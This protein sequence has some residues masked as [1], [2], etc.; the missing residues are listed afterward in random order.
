MKLSL[1]KPISYFKTHAEELLEGLEES[2]EPIAITQNGEVRAVVQNAASFERTQ[3]A[4]ALLRLL[5]L[6]RR[7]IELG[8]TTNVREASA[9]RRRVPASKSNGQEIIRRDA[10]NCRPAR[11]MRHLAS[12][13]L[14]VAHASARECVPRHG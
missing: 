14:T 9:A 6:G 2:Q 13:Q 1:V 7:E 5:A 8:R 4:L 12:A 11:A 10:T 3:E